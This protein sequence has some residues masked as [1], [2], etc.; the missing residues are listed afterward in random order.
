MQKPIVVENT[1]FEDQHNCQV[2]LLI[3]S[4]YCRHILKICVA[5]QRLLKEGSLERGVCPGKAIRTHLVLTLY[6]W[7]LAYGIG[8]Q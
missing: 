3:N 1:N 5:F 4:E 7:I 8:L 6:Q 2:Y